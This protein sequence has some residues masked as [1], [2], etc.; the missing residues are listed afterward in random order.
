[1]GDVAFNRGVGTYLDHARN[2]LTVEWLNAQLID[3]VKLGKHNIE[4]GFQYR[5]EFIK[6]QLNEW[7]LVD[8]AGF[9]LPK[10]KG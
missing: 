2:Y 9:S 1:M 3:N 6:D 5:G 4:Y 8:S 7:V 10:T